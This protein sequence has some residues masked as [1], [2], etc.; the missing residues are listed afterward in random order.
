MVEENR[1]VQ[2]ERQAIQQQQYAAED[3]KE[4]SL[5]HLYQLMEIDEQREFFPIK[6]KC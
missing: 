2:R 1:I 3:H 5:N 4:C 6:R